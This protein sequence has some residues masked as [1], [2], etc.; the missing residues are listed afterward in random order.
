MGVSLAAT[1]ADILKRPKLKSVLIVGWNTEAVELYEHLLNTPSLGYD[2]RAFLSLNPDLNRKHYK[3]VPIVAGLDK[4]AEAVDK[5]QIEEVLIIL[6]PAEKDFLGQIIKLCTSKGIEYKI[7]SDAYDEEYGHIIRDVI[8]DA[9]SREDFGLRRIFDFVGSLVLLFLLLPLF[10]IVAIAIKIESPGPIF[11]SQNRYGKDGKIFKVYK[12]RSMVA[13]AEKKS[14]PVWA[15]KNDPRVTRVGRFMRKT[16]IDELP[17]LMNI[18]KGD[19]SFIGPR[20]ERPFFAENFKKKIPFYMNRLKVKPGITG[21]A[22]VTVGYDET[23]E[24]V[25][26]KV[27]RD[28]EYIERRRSLK[29]NLYIL[30]KTVSAVLRGEGQ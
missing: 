7:V 11:Y 23:L 18:I 8:R 29:M 21:L 4:F 3:N 2:A 5:W 30:L 6:S 26:Q 16:R 9:W 27:A 1:T 12:F 19:M 15:S 13:D 17:Q 22:Q 20:P 14:G 28:L 25:K 24:D 10:I